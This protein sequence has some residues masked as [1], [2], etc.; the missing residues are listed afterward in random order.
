MASR[1]AVARY[2]GQSADVAM[3]AAELGVNAVLEGSV[4]RA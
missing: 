3:V 1:N 4:R 2:R